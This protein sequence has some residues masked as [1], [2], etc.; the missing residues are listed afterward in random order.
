MEATSRLTELVAVYQEELRR[1]RQMLALADEQKRCVE[2]SNYPVLVEILERR[3]RLAEEI[4][5]ASAQV[6]A[7]CQQ[8]SQE[9]GLPEVNL[10]NLRSR[11]SEDVLSPLTTVLADISATI[12]QIQALDTASETE[13]KQVLD[14]LRGQMSPE[15]RGQ[16]ALRAYKQGMGAGPRPSQEKK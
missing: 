12:G 9:L 10:T 2:A 14:T 4:T 5:A 8:I 16:A 13:I 6:R 15:R 7:V 3:D 1:Y 11:L